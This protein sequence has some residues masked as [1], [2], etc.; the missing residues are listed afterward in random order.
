MKPEEPVTN[1]RNDM[2]DPG[3]FKGRLEFRSD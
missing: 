3:R 2:F 1:I